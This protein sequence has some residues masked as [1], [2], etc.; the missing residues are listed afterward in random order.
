MSMPF[1]LQP[2]QLK[3]IDTLMYASN[4]QYNKKCVLCGDIRDRLVNHYVKEHAND[5]VFISR[6]SELMRHRIQ[7]NRVPESSWVK[8]SLQAFCIFCETICKK[9]KIAVWLE[10]LTVHTGEY[11]WRCNKCEQHFSSRNNHAYSSCSKFLIQTT[12]IPVE[13]DGVYGYICN[14]CNYVQFKEEALQK[15]VTQQHDAL[16]PGSSHYTSIRILKLPNVDG[17]TEQQ[18]LTDIQQEIPKSVWCGNACIRADCFFCQQPRTF[19]EMQ[20]IDH[21]A[22][23]TGER[24]FKCLY[25]YQNV[26]EKHEHLNGKCKSKTTEEPLHIDVISDESGIYGFACNTCDATYLTRGRVFQHIRNEHDV[27]D[28]S[29][30]Q[31][32]RMLLLP[33]PQAASNASQLPCDGI[34]SRKIPVQALKKYDEGQIEQ[35]MWLEN[36]KFGVF[37]LLCQN[38]HHFTKIQWVEHI[39]ER[40]GESIY[41]CRLC[42]LAS[43]RPEEHLPCRAQF[44]LLPSLW[45]NNSIA[46]HYCRICNYVQ[47]SQHHIIRHI[48]EEHKLSTA[49]NCAEITILNL[50]V[51]STKY[52]HNNNKSIRYANKK[53]QSVCLLCNATLDINVPPN[54]VQHCIENHPGDEI[55]TSRIS[56]DMLE[57]IQNAKLPA[58]SRTPFNQIEA[59][60]AFCEEKKSFTVTKW[61]EH[62]TSHTGEFQYKCSG[63]NRAVISGD[64]HECLRG[65]SAE[66]QQVRSFASTKELYAFV[67]TYCNYVQL[68]EENIVQ[69]IE[70]LHWYGNCNS[71]L[72][73]IKL[74]NFK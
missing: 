17:E 6:I 46:G 19:N 52:T 66:I 36:G 31:C 4:A 9:S 2:K 18:Q 67:C 58:S 12:K 65:A 59:L 37:C 8:S 72:A 38:I 56:D 50:N 41:E 27:F 16:A 45:Q 22:K 47:L 42:G 74:L 43:S 54:I 26:A 15:H 14:A 68:Q 62:T 32:H 57:L 55:Y 5:E 24:Q 53:Y 49:D 39:A 28:I 21:L 29:D 20:W 40:L 44:N 10:H 70:K 63:C 71:N 69:H 11:M 48:R 60:C 34:W 51:V 1:E 33:F 25:C 3:N 13:N 23:H 64:S 7:T 73:K 35:A 30:D 61:I